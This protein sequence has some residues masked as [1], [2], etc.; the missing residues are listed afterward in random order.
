MATWSAV[1]KLQKCTTNLVE[2]A[3]LR[4]SV[5]F[6]IFVVSI[7]LVFY[8]NVLPPSTQQRKYV[9][10][11]TYANLS[12]CEFVE[13]NGV[14]KLLCLDIRQEGKTTQRQAELVLTRMLRVFDLIAKKYGIRY[15]LYKGT[16]L[17]AVR[18]GRHNP[19]DN[20]LDI[21]VL[22]RDYEVFIREGAKELPEDM[23]L[24][25]EETD[26][27]WQVVP[28][29]NMLGKIRDTKSCYNYC[30]GY[31]CKIRN[32]LMVDIFV[33]DQDN[34]GGLV[35]A[36]SYRSW[37]FRYLFGPL[38]APSN[39]V[40]PL[41]QMVFDGFHFPVP[42]QWHKVL[43]AKYGV[44]YAEMPNQHRFALEKVDPLRA[45]AYD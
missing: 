23:F 18:N 45:C 20:D 3:R 34:S 41:A 15:W 32:G 25:T 38:R 6:F 16:L 17:G 21:A 36:F 13:K 28:Y 9:S 4:R 24:Q 33:I 29:S 42:N 44:V 10:S 27:H 11:A 37:I 1:S 26:P 40:F 43:V 12:Q 35:E 30:S 2:N 5:A 19:F 31:G 7:L 22:R 39:H 8:L 14:E